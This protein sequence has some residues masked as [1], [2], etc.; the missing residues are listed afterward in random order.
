MKFSQI[1]K[2]DLLKAWIAVSFAF[3]V[4]NSSVFSLTFVIFL[5]CVML[6]NLSKFSSPFVK[7]F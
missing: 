6:L 1:E 5:C 3:A 7:L 4:L 2:Q